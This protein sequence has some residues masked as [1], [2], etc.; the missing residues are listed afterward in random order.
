MQIGQFYPAESS[1]AQARRLVK[2]CVII[3]CWR[4]DDIVQ[5]RTQFV[6]IR[7]DQVTFYPGTHMPACVSAGGRAILAHEMKEKLD[8]Y[9]KNVKLKRYTRRTRLPQRRI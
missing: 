1:M 6:S 3:G 8:A 7:F 9:I 4:E 5:Y 2:T